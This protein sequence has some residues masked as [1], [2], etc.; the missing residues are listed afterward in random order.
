MTI[1]E[2]Q[3][4]QDERL[5]VRGRRSM[6]T[7]EECEKE[8][9]RLKQQHQEL[10]QLAHELFSQRRGDPLAF[11]DWSLIRTV[12]VVWFLRLVNRFSVR[13]LRRFAEQMKAIRI[14]REWQR[15]HKIPTPDEVEARG[16][17]WIE[18]DDA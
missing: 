8:I 4:E 9:Q 16:G 5:E 11:F 17:A 15:T 1:T 6:A 13:L 18:E 7:E 3:H 14:A 10:E 2:H 12:F